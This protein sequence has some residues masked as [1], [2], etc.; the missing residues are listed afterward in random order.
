MV[1]ALMRMFLMVSSYPALAEAE[2]ANPREAVE[3]ERAAVL[4]ELANTFSSV[5]AQCFSGLF[6]RVARPAVQ[7]M[8]PQSAGSRNLLAIDGDGVN[9][10]IGPFRD[11]CT[12]VSVCPA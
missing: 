6:Q 2:D 5:S 4:S 1:D 9:K 10:R 11:I 8:C 3:A 12:A 7:M